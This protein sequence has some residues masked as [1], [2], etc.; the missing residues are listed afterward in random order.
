MSGACLAHGCDSRPGPVWVSREG[1]KV[2]WAEEE[3]ICSLAQ[4]LVDFVLYTVVTSRF[5][6]RRCFQEGQPEGLACEPCALGEERKRLSALVVLIAELA[7][8]PLSTFQIL[9]HP[10]PTLDFRQIELLTLPLTCCILSC[11]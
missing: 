7:P 4:D 9:L 8:G 11:L 10:S 3:F 1:G 6:A 2:F 5:S